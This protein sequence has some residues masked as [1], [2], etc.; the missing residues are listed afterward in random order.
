[1]LIILRRHET[2]LEI[3][4]FVINSKEYWGKYLREFSNSNSN[5]I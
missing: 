1:M 5:Y 4:K 3:C 2:A